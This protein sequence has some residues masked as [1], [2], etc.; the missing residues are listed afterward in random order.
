[1]FEH[2]S[3]KHRPRVVRCSRASIWGLL[4]LLLVGLPAC[5]SYSYTPHPPRVS[6]ALGELH[7]DRAAVELY[8]ATDRRITGA[9]SPSLYYGAERTNELR[10]GDAVVSIPAE[11][12]RGRL[13]SPLFGEGDPARHVKLTQLSPPLERAE[14]LDRLRAQIELSPRREVFVFIHGYANLFSYATRRTAQIAHDS[15]FA[16]VALTYSWPTQGWLLAYL[17]DGVN[18]EWTVPHLVDF[19]TLLADESGAER[20]HLMGHS[21]GTRVLTHALKESVR[22]RSPANRQMFDQ[23]VLVAADMDAELFERDYAPFIVQSCQRLTL[24]ISGADWALGGSRRMH[25]YARLGQVGPTNPSAPWL[26]QIDIID[27]TA[28]DKGPVGHVYYCQSPAFLEDLA[29]LLRGE[30][31]QQRGLRRDGNVYK[32]E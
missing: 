17:I 7:P 13:E 20:I 6:P 9:T 32:L 30:S 2:P 10:L 27:A 21:M 25:K 12:G 3:K 24:Y 22:E 26:N 28:V 11:H 19:L 4:A 15:D 18:A 14:F 1:M 8:Y 23:I 31:P 5:S 29:G 16:G